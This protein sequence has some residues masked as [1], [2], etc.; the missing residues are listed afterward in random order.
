MNCSIPLLLSRETLERANAKIDIGNATIQML[1]ATVPM[2]TTSSGHFCLPIGRSYD[3]SNSETKRVLSDVLY[4]SPLEGIG[5]DLK[6]KVKKLHS[7]FAHPTAERL[8]TL[9][10]NAGTSDTKVFDTIREI[11]SNCDVCARHKKPPLRPAVGFP[12]A[13]QF[14]E[15][16]AIDLKV[17]GPNLY[18]LHMIDH[19]TRYSS[20]CIIHDK[21]KETIVK[22]MLNY[23]IR[24][25]GCPK[26]FLSDNGGEFV[27]QDVIDLAE[28]CNISLRTTAAESAW[29]N[30]LCEK[31]NGILNASVNKVMSSNDCSLEVAIHWA[32]AAKN[33]LSNV[34]GFSPNILVFG[35]N[36]N[37]PSGFV[38][39][40][41]ANNLHCV[42]DYV[43]E[44][45]N[46]MYLARKAFIEQES[47]ER[48]RRA[49]NRK[50]RTYSNVVFCQGDQVYY[51]RN[52]STEWH[53]PAV[54]IGRDGQQ[55]LVKHGGYYVRVHPCR[56][57]HCRQPDM[58]LIESNGDDIE[59][60]HGNMST[61]LPES[62]P[63]TDTVPHPDAE[64][65]SDSD[66]VDS[67]S[68]ADR[69]PTTTA[70]E[71]NSSVP[72]AMEAESSSSSNNVSSSESWVNVR[73]H[74][75]LPKVNS[76]IDCKFPNQD[77]K[78]RC[79]VLSKAGKASTSN[80]HFLNIQEDDNVG[81]CC[82]FKD[83][84]WK[85]A[86][87]NEEALETVET[88]FGSCTDDPAY[89]QPKIDEMNKWRFFKT[90]EEVPNTG[91]D[92]ISTRWVCTR[93]IKGGKVTHKARL[94]ARGFEENSK[95][96]KTDSPTCS[97]ESLRLVLAIISSNAWKL[98]SLDVKSAFLQGAPIE[99][100]VFIKPPKEANTSFLWKMLLAPYGL[101]DAGRQW[102]VRWKGEIM[103]IGMVPCKYDQAL[104]MWYE[105][106]VLAGIM[107]CHVDDILYGGSQQF[108]SEIIS[109]IRSIFAIGLEEDTNMKYLGLAICQNASG[110]HV[111]TMDYASSLKE[112]KLTDVDSCQHAE[113]SSEQTTL[114]KQ[115]CGQVNWLSSQGRPDIAFDCCYI[116][117][118]MKSGDPKVFSAANKVI[119]KA[120]NQDIVLHFYSDFDFSSCSVISFCDASF[121]NLP[122]AG[123]QGGFICLLVDKNGVYFPIA[124]QSRK[125]KRVVKSTLAAEC[126]SAV[127]AAELIVYIS[128]LIR[129]VFQN[130]DMAIDTFVYCDNKNLVNAVHSSTNL[131]D[132]RLVIDVSVLR[133]QLQQNELT[134]FVW[135]S[136]KSQLADTLT[137]Q[138]ASDKQLINVFNKKLHFNF[139]TICFE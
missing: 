124:W 39:K 42:N 14:N 68:H 123:S 58:Q 21:K 48:L 35:R 3:V 74:K 18:I 82:S 114:L 135:V 4:T 87:E 46:A 2:I 118:S 20:A 45:L 51:W 133:D 26:Y 24:I 36:P 89:I 23:W 132:R 105:N 12:L 76:D 60:E 30:G 95:S 63:T 129:N 97:K 108:H 96:L 61:S 88:L 101:N 69:Q 31:H 6:N 15:T 41:P 117:N 79:K 40:P 44:N 107:A 66:T 59:N 91:Q 56:L 85:P 81:K 32:V 93:K 27:N 127:E 75:D 49:L 122:N 52:N 103:L 65:L 138:G 90:F 134:D 126:L 136:K 128:E 98:H 94:V 77:W 16:V 57:Q 54:V 70:T 10:K 110:I 131:D 11:T 116:A 71:N 125:V 25:F 47:A 38:N 50:S 78:I 13:S 130:P 121:A 115:F 19:L 33:S 119:R 43:A 67:D 106:G 22:A 111:S 37:Y 109:K 102:Y 29:S 113:F 83:A 55:V 1:G 137:K 73:S 28:K 120:Q 5:S 8:I 84:M 86:E 9:I 99:R 80:W 17:R 53:G 92:T 112:I 139:N 64:S 34:Y 72:S 7:Q 62:E 100:D 104:F